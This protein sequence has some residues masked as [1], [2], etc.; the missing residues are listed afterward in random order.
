[1]PI[2]GKRAARIEDWKPIMPTYS[3]GVTAGYRLPNKPLYSIDTAKVQTYGHRTAQC[4]HVIDG[5]AERW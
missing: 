3:S 5:I 2:R 4:V 1:M